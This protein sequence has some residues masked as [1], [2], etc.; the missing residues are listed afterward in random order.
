MS[1]TWYENRYPGCA[2]D[3]PSH[4]YV[5]SFEP[6]A[7]WSSV[8]AGSSE[9]RSYFADFAKKYGLARFIR[10]SRLVTETKWDAEKGRWIVM[11]QDLESGETTSDWCHILVHATGYLNKPAWPSVPGLEDYKGTKLHSADYDDSVSLAGRDVLLIGGG[12]SAV[13]ILPAI[14]PIAKSVKIFIRSPVWVLPDISTE[15][16]TFSNEQIEEFVKNPQSVLKLRQN[17][18]RTMNS[19]FSMLLLSVDTVDFDADIS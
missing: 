15:A 18:E 3:V 1:G 7:D 11:I 5:Y 19:I 17:N 16:G 14:Q 6:K 13:Q 4:N 9:I 10:L 2:C 8:Y 12:S